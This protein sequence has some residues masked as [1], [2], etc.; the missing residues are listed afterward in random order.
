MKNLVT[1]VGLC[2]FIFLVF[3]ILGV[4]LFKGVCVRERESARARARER[5]SERE[6]GREGGRERI[7]VCVCVCVYL[8]LF[9]RVSVWV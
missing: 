3:G 8:Q 1:V 2:A 5:E 6:G 9:K 4:Q 7:C